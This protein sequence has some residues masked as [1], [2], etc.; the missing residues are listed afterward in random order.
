M[1]GDAIYLLGDGEVDSGVGQL[2]GVGVS[3]AASAFADESLDLVGTRTEGLLFR[4]GGGDGTNGDGVRSRG[5][6]DD[7]LTTSTII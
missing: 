3:A 7:Q 5:K 1:Q 6:V 4:G 2:E